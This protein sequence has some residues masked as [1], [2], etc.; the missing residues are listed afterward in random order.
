MPAIVVDQLHK[1]YGDL[2]AVKGIS[3][4]VKEGEIFALLGPNGA[5]KTTTV[6]ILEG[7]RPR[8]SGTVEVLGFDPA[9]RPEEMRARIGIV[10]QSAG[11]ESYLTVAEVV[12]LY[13][14]Y[15]PKPRDRDEVL[16]LVGLED[17]PAVRVGRLSGG[18]RR[19][20]D[21]ALGICGDPDLLFLDEPTTGFDPAARRNAWATISGL[22]DEG[23]TILLTTHF[24][25][26]AQ[27]LAD[28]LAIMRGGEIVAMGTI[29]EIQS[30]RP[31]ATRIR[32]EVGDAAPPAEL[33]PAGSE[34]HD[35]GYEVWSDAPVELLHKLTGWA[36]DS[37]LELNN[38]SVSRPSLEDTY[39]E[40]TG[41][42]AEQSARE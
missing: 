38:L 3:L 41:E 8:T 28:R 4:T 17:R 9:R 15:Y 20:L 14:G 37:H 22:R 12:D 33:L 1:S 23:K 29:D 34:R 36:L 32:F 13:R 31:S 42:L 26:E 27:A 5:G 7:Y 24:M 25:D 2:E 10:L 21:V 19:R 30:A 39:L 6:E 40:L 16:K 18:Q 35:G 11:V